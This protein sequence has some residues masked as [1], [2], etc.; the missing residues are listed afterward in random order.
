MPGVV[1]ASIALL[2]SMSLLSATSRTSTP[3]A[4]R[5]YKN[6]LFKRDAASIRRPFAGFSGLW[7]RHIMRFDVT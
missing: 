4:Y 2:L 3:N 1:I 6:K 5:S 7:Q